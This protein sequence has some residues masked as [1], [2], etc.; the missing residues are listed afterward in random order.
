[1]LRSAHGA[2]AFLYPV[3]DPNALHGF[4]VLSIFHPDDDVIN[5]VVISQFQIVG[6][7]LGAYKVQGDEVSFGV[8]ELPSSTQKFRG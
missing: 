4:D 8:Q 7:C 3:V 2:R 6:E 1:M 5:S